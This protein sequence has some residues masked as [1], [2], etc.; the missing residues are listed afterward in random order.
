MLVVMNNIF[1][2]IDALNTGLYE[3]LTD[4]Q[5][6]KILNYNGPDSIDTQEKSDIMSEKK[7][8]I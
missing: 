5:K 4:E 6:V 2:P 8:E 1:T 7:Q 3:N